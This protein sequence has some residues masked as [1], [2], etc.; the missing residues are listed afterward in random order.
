[1]WKPRSAV[2]RGNTNIIVTDKFG[3]FCLI[4][5]LQNGE[6]PHYRY[7]MKTHDDFYYSSKAQVTQWME[8]SNLKQMIC[9]DSIDL[10]F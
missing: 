9:S 1:M 2:P 6:Q 8:I 3:G 5:T 4:R 7:M 10:H